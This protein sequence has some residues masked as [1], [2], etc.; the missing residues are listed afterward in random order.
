MIIETAIQKELSGTAAVSAL[1]SNR[2]YFVK[3]PQDVIKPYIVF[4]KV[5]APR[6]HTH[7]GAAGLVEARFQFDVFATTYIAAK[8]IA[9]QIQAILQGYSGTMGGAG[10]V[11][12]NGCFYDDEQDLWEEDTNLY[13]IAM[14]FLM[15]VS[16]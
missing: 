11:Y 8:A 3:A 5:S 1:V 7:D 10:G 13:H 16:E 6:E 15:W 4:F 2:I 9:G 12:V 14:D